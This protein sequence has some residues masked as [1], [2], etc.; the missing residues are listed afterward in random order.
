MFKQVDFI[1][2]AIHVRL[3]PLSL[4]DKAKMWLNS[5]ALG[6]ISIWEELAQNFLQ[7]ISLLPRQ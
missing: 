2:D 5:L 1:D 7:N 6:T 4:R 3:F